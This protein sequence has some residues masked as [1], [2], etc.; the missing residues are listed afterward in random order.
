M[1]KIIY[2]LS[3]LFEIFKIDIIAKKIREIFKK[4]IK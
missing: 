4:F 3:K 2:R 1:G